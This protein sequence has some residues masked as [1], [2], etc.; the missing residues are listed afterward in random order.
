MLFHL[1]SFCLMLTLS[2]LYGSDL[3]WRAVVG[4]WVAFI[5]VSFVV[6]DVLQ[7]PWIAL[8]IKIGLALAMYVKAHKGSSSF[9]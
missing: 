7:A 1:G 5:L 9:G 8:L 6:G 3:G 4:F 2:I